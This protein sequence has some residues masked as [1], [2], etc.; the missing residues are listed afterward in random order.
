[1]TADKP[2]HPLLIMIELS[3]FIKQNLI[4]HAYIITNMKT[5]ITLLL[6]WIF[7]EVGP[8]LHK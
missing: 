8:D 5:I 1:M 7:G 6:S 2:T 3:N 4:W